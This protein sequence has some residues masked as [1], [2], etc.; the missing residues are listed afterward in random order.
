MY[1]SVWSAVLVDGELSVWFSLNIGLRQGCV[2]SPLLFDLFINGVAEQLK[3]KGL[4]VPVLGSHLSIL[5]F[6]DD[7]VLVASSEQELQQMLDEVGLYCSRWRCDVN[8]R[9]SEVVAFGHEGVCTYGFSI[10]GQALSVVPG[11]KYL[12]LD[13][14]ASLRWGQMQS[15]LYAKARA[16]VASA[17][18]MANCA[19]LLNVDFG[20][21]LWRTLIRPILEYG[22]EVWGDDE[23]KEGEALQRMV[24]K[25]ILKCAES[26]SD[27]A[28]LGELGWWRLK[29]R[30]DMLRLRFWGHLVNT[31]LSSITKQVYEVAKWDLE[32]DEAGLA[33]LR[34]PLPVLDGLDVEQRKRAMHRFEKPAVEQRRRNWC[35][36]TKELL[37]RYGLAEY[38]SAAWLPSNWDAIVFKA[39]KEAEEREW[40]A[41]VALRPKLRTYRLLKCELKCE[42]YLL[43]SDG[44]KSVYDLFKLRCGTNVLRIE[45]GRYERIT[46]ANGK[47]VKKPEALRT[48]LFCLNGVETE[49]HFLLDCPV[50]ESEREHCFNQLG[51]ALRQEGVNFNSLTRQQRVQ[52]ILL[53]T[54]FADY[55]DVTMPILKAFIGKVYGKR[56]RMNKYLR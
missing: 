11:Y 27:E 48:C 31:P 18:G 35:F 21:Q 51:E 50:F 10:N 7:I 32:H 54:S 6:A 44:E 46:D 14:Y 53:G 41:M 26:T 49:V 33:V 25:R 24:A 13:V 30:A 34:R 40:H 43:R 17:F 22:V 39:V 1:D 56:Q 3:A 16:K 9:K 29:A 2:L 47:K 15:R 12:G 42:R 55:H 20:V 23:W 4:G 37:T 38:W 19:E 52:L 36:G 45:T 5:L 28:V 8:A